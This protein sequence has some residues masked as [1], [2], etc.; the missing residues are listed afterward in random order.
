MDCDRLRCHGKPSGWGHSTLKGALD[1]V[2][3]RASLP[4]FARPLR[5]SACSCRLLPCGLD[6]ASFMTRDLP[7][8]LLKA[9]E[10]HP[11]ASCLR[12]VPAETLEAL[13]SL[14]TSRG[15]AKAAPM[16]GSSGGVNNDGSWSSSRGGGEKG[17]GSG[18]VAGGHSSPTGMAFGSGY[19]RGGARR[20]LTTE[21]LAHARHL[22]AEVQRVSA[23]LFLPPF[24]GVREV[25]QP[26]VRTSPP[27]GPAPL[28]TV[29][30]SWQ[31][32][33]W[34][35]LSIPGRSGLMG[36]GSAPLVLPSHHLIGLALRQCTRPCRRS[37]HQY[38]VLRRTA[39]TV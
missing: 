12:D 22:S 6:P 23:R 27:Q 16:G 37:D 10:H 32:G 14:G 34:K 7:A 18:S 29:L 24:G 4:A 28:Y 26:R 20:R 9:R 21:V 30:E 31:P 5:P 25:Y 3:P 19:G 36:A 1:E 2:P 35:C 13:L 38:P 8:S 33:R 39:E 11:E 17:C 15:Q